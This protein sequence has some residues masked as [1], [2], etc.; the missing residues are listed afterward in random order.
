[1][2][3]PPFSQAIMIAERAGGKKTRH[4]RHPPAEAHV[5]EAPSKPTPAHQKAINR[6][7]YRAKRHLANM[8]WKQWGKLPGVAFDSNVTPF[9]T[10]TALDFPLYTNTAVDLDDKG[11]KLSMTSALNSN[12]GQTT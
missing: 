9:F 8:D 1:M 11:K 5:W 4:R 2:S 6:A 3:A 10:A 12:E 7:I